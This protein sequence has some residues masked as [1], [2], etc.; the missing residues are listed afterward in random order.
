L[1][2]ENGCV[3]ELYTI[4]KNYTIN[5]TLREPLEESLLYGTAVRTSSLLSAL[6]W[7]LAIN[8]SIG[9]TTIAVV[10]IIAIGSVVVIIFGVAK[11][12]ELVIG[13]S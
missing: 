12:V 13:Q 1:I 4:R 3:L 6:E 5:I 11:W 9:I 2:L 10:I 7:I 8:I